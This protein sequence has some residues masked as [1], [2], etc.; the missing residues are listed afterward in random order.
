MDTFLQDFRYALR[1]LLKRPV[2]TAVAVFA[3]ALGIGATSAIFSVVNAV[4]L[5]SLPYAEPGRLTFLAETF[6]GRTDQTGS[7]S[8]PNFTDWR[9]RSES[10]E[11]LA[12][13][14]SKEFILRKGDT[15]ERVHGAAVSADLF[16]L[17]GV[18]P[19]VGQ[20]LNQRGADLTIRSRVPGHYE[21]PGEILDVTAAEYA[22]LFPLR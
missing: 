2:F 1:M 9:D 4:L 15:S 8:Y 16:P 17:L 13:F 5:R 3:L 22:A 19:E 20:L 7:V 10:F 11:H 12:A 14:T 21:R 6:R 18:N